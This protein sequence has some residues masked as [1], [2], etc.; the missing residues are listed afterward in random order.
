MDNKIVLMLVLGGVGILSA[1]LTLWLRDRVITRGMSPEQR[2][3]KLENFSDQT[4][5]VANKIKGTI[6]GIALLLAAFDTYRSGA[7]RATL[8]VLGAGILI[9]SWKIHNKQ[10]VNSDS[11][12][13]PIE[14]E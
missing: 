5:G 13:K 9:Y 14:P 7:V 2:K 11:D 6:I 4:R 12:A 1:A 3:A 8:F 10:A